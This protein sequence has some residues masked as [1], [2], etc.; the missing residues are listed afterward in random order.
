MAEKSKE[1]PV[2]ASDINAKEPRPK[3]SVASF[4]AFARPTGL[5]LPEQITFQQWQAI[6]R[7]L[8][9]FQR[10]SSWW[11]GDWWPHDEK[12][13]PGKHWSGGPLT[14]SPSSRQSMSPR[15]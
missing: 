2:T 1:L 3:L 15:D 13:E 12:R 7:E 6:G 11:I 8:G 14:A 10:A 5:Q 9:R 4:E